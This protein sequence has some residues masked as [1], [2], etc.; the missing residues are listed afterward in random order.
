MKSNQYTNSNNKEKNMKILP[1]L[2][3]LLLTINQ[4]HADT[5]DKPEENLKEYDIEIIIF[6]DEILLDK[7]IFLIGFFLIFN[8]NSI[9]QNNI[10][11]MMVL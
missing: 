5:K 2:F 11:N 6:E 3:L 4:T 1:T 8:V 9:N 10:N 7:K